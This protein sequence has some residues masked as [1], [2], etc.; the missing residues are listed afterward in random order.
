MTSTVDELGAVDCLV[1]EFPGSKFNGEIAPKLMELVDSGP[2]ESSTSWC[3]RRT[4]TAPSRRSRCLMASGGDRVA[5]A[6]CPR[7]GGSAGA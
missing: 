2:N 7:A 5:L 1:V 3:C 6:E 4:T